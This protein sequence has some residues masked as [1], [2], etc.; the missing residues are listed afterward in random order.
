M[1]QRANKQARRVGH[2]APPCRSAYKGSRATK[3]DSL[4][5]LSSS[6]PFFRFAVERR[7]VANTDAARTLACVPTV[8]MGGF[9]QSEL[10][11]DG[12]CSTF[13]VATT[14]KLQFH[15]LGFLHGVRDVKDTRV[16]VPRVFSSRSLWVFIVLNAH[17]CLP[18]QYLCLITYF[19]G[20]K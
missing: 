11:T 15:C 19:R 12:M 17:S 4:L 7:D 13:P 10:Q 8:K 16:R 20:K 2:Q 9:I 6:S 3:A 1:K 5:P 18:M 14:P